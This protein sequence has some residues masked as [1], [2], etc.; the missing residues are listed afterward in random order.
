MFIEG[1]IQQV[2]HTTTLG[3]PVTRF[4]IP[5]RDPKTKKTSWTNITAWNP[6]N[7]EEFRNGRTARMIFH[8]EPKLLGGFFN[9]LT[10]IAFEITDQD[11]QMDLPF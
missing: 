3:T 8:K 4:S 1:R 5:S 11:R 6:Q 2:K 9:N 7:P 10:D